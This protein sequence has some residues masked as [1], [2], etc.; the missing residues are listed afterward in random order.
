MGVH[1]APFKAY[2]G[3][4]ANSAWLIFLREATISQS[5]KKYHEA[6]TYSGAVIFTPLK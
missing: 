3:C 5:I 2:S 1:E 6:E 4:A